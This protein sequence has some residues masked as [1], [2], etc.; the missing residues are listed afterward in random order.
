M[1]MHPVHVGC[2]VADVVHGGALTEHAARV[3]CYA[4]AMRLASCT[5][6]RYSLHCCAVREREVC[7]M[8]VRVRQQDSW[9]R[10][11][12]V[13]G[14]HVHVYGRNTADAVCVREVGAEGGARG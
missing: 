14:V 2:C 10:V 1:P 7:I 12:C 11:R 6:E 9:R 4:V 5:W 3:G 8:K 13:W